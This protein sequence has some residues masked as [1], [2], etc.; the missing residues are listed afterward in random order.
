M[1]PHNVSGQLFVLCRPDLS[2]D[3]VFR[4]FQLDPLLS[5]E[6]RISSTPTNAHP[7][8]RRKA[9][10]AFFCNNSSSSSVLTVFVDAFENIAEII[11]FYSSSFCLAA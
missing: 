5:R 2:R 3:S 11:I 4:S 7:S 8:E 6:A 1:P 9:N 10:K